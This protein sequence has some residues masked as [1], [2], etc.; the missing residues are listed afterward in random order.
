MLSNSISFEPKTC[1]Q[2]KQIIAYLSQKSG[3]AWLGTEGDLGTGLTLHHQSFD[4]YGQHEMVQQHH[5]LS[6]LHPKN[7]LD[8]P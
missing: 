7:S 4:P 3:L 8:A 2:S 5:K 6:P 1:W